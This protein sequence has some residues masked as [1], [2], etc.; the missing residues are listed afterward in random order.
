MENNKFI[1]SN[2]KFILSFSYLYLIAGDPSYTHTKNYDNFPMLR[3]SIKIVKISIILSSSI[4][5]NLD[6]MI[7][8]SLVDEP[9]E[10]HKFHC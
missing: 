2:F 1:M 5:K 7:F 3:K 8:D 9:K 4:I 6:L 10:W